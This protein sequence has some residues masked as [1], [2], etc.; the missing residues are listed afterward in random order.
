MHVKP[1]AIALTAALAG[2]TTMPD[3]A[4]RA[5]ATIAPTSAAKGKNVA[6][7]VSLTQLSGKVLVE[8]T[9]AGLN[10]NQEHG[11][12][13]HAVA[14]CSGDGMKTG[15]HFNPDD[16]PHAHPRERA[17]HAGA[18]YNLRADANGVAKFRQEV[19]TITLT[20]GKYGVI[21]MPIIIHAAPDDYMSQPLGNA[22]PRIGCG[23]IQAGAR[24][25]G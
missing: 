18:M 11:F 24:R 22:G 8:A 10:P 12:H 21:G 7:T 13:V 4:P 23:L 2:C 15:A 25:T 5:Q 17:R 3:Q 16:H 1:L 6:G 20:P 19:D 14:D 9:I